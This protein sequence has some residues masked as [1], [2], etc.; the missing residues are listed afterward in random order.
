[1]SKII[2]EELYVILDEKNSAR[3]IS[4]RNT[5][6]DEFV[7]FYTGKYICLIKLAIL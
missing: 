7:F 5:S 1:M 2:S 4:K 3:L 6:D